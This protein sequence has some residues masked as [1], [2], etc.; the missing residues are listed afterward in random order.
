M[1]A[2]KLT[3]VALCVAGGL[4]L[5][6]CGSSPSTPT[7]SATPIVG[8]PQPTPT[9]TPTATPSPTPTG[10]SGLPAGMICSPTPP[11]FYRM[12]A[13]IHSG[14]NPERLVL[15]SKPLV[16]NVDGFCD[17]VGFGAWKFCDTRVEG[18]EQR[19]ACDWLVTGK[20]SDTGRW[21]PTWYYGDRLCSDAPE[22]CANHPSNQYMAVA[23]AKGTY[24]VCAADVWPLASNGMRCGSIEVK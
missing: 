15:D 17:R 7:S 19:V 21:G 22:A 20:A 13:K 16:I 5:A 9:A 12:Q 4:G 2:R 18:D 1:N 23:K 3:L 6:G 24:S 14:D 10:S 11:P 8:I